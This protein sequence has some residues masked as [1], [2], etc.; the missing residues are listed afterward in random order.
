M[1]ASGNGIGSFKLD[2]TVILSVTAGTH[3]VHISTVFTSPSAGYV[4]FTSDQVATV[5]AVCTAN[6]TDPSIS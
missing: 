4:S 6:T 5:T 1:T 2:G 3:S